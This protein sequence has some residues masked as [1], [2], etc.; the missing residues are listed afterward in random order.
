MIARQFYLEIQLE[1]GFIEEMRTT[2]GNKEVF[3]TFFPQ[4]F[5]FS[6]MR[7][8]PFDSVPL[9]TLHFAIL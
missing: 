7:F 2:R 9:A 4:I 5:L 8:N 1:I 3:Q 6:K